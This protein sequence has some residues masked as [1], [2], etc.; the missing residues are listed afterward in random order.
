[1]RVIE[2][3]PLASHILFETA[4]FASVGY[5]LIGLDEIAVDLLWLARA[6]WHFLVIDRVTPR[7]SVD[8]LPKSD[9]SAWFAVLIPAYDEAGVIG[10]M[11]DNALEHY[12]GRNVHVFVGCYSCDP[13]TIDVVRR[14]QGPGL[15]LIVLQRSAGTTKGDCL[16]TLCRAIPEHEHRF[17][18][19]FAGFILHDAEDV[20]DRYEIPV[21]AA[22]VER[23]AMIQLPVIPL[24]NSNSRLVGGHYCDEFAE[25]HGKTMVVRQMLG[26]GLPSAGVGCMIRRDAIEAMVGHNK[27][28]PFDENC[29][30]EDYECG[31]R[32]AALGFDTAFLRVRAP[33]EFGLVATTAYFPSE[34]GKALTQ[35]TRWISGIALAG[36]DRMRWGRGLAEN[37]MRMRDRIPVL[38]AVVS[39]AG[40]AAA[41]VAAPMIASAWLG[42]SRPVVLGEG[43]ADLIAANGL[44][45]LWRMSFRA[46]FTARL[47]GVKQSLLAVPR[48]VVSNVIGILS[49]RR[50]IPK[51]LAEVRTGRVNWEKTAHIFPDSVL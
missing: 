17:D 30:T 48:I 47:Y 35:K 37:W 38:S 24:P 12:A 26:A 45:L 9:G 25:S 19:R 3:P 14:Y 27:G 13:P 44:I 31:L 2:L 28:S 50:A 46:G 18:R 33:N 21:F 20:V 23:Y 1:M 36:W 16:N 6:A 15:S 32:L 22:F 49:V 51:H 29:A 10:E 39:L 11:L 4:L 42:A 5:F 34:L 43:L 40:Y 8:A 7:L 41:I